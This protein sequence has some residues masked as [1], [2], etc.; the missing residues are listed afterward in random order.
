[1]DNATYAQQRAEN[2][3]RQP[4]LG[5]AYN[6]QQHEPTAADPDHDELSST[7][8]AVVFGSIWVRIASAVVP[9]MAS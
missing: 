8:L 6:S 1:M 5:G 4:L 3:E 9:L 2:A 7:R